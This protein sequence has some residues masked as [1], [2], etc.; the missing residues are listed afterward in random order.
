MAHIPVL[1]EEVMKGLRCHPGGLY[2]DCTVGEGGH[3]EEILK[4]TSPEGRLIACDRD[5]EAIRRAQA[6]LTHYGERVTFVHENF[7]HL[8]KALALCGVDGIFFDLGLS[9]H[10][11]EDPARGFSFLAEGPLDMRMDRRERTTAADLA[12]R[13]SER[14][15]SRLL[16]TYGEE[17]WARRIA[18]A[19][20]RRR[21]RSPYQ[22]T[23]DL[24]DT[25]ITSLPPFALSRRIHPAT[26]TF[27]ALRIAVNRELEG[28]GA[29]LTDA[30]SL[31]KPGG[32]LAVVS[33]HSLEDRIVKQTVR[34]M[35]REGKV[36]VLTKKPVTPGQE[37]MR[38]N[39]SSRS[40]KLR[41]AERAA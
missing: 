26:K 30:V 33:F 39:P 12:N 2:I 7:F 27:Q 14:D 31:L 4:R 32:R 3:A 35:A 16:A 18:R 25:I 11:I 37:E 1:V 6:R 10:Q 15:L 34:E 41:V 22:T 5:E 38:A 17:R 28:L 23:R 19:L 29:A 13:L 8:K 40:A 24:V 21:A 36:I 20:V 9:S